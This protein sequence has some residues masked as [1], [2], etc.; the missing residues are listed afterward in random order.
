MTLDAFC[1]NISFL[2][3]TYEIFGQYEGT[4]GQLTANV[5]VCAIVSSRLDYCNILLAGICGSNNLDKL[6]CVQN[7]LARVVTGACHRGQIN[8]ILKEFHWLP[9]LARM[10]FKIM[11]PVHK[12]RTSHQPSYLVAQVINIDGPVRTLHSSLITPGET[13]IE[14][15][16]WSPLFLLLCFQVME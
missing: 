16:N 8:P 7:C 10:C 3:L 4:M 5:V 12:V 6:P 11:T 1:L 9:I 2:T 15:F 14:D 13:A